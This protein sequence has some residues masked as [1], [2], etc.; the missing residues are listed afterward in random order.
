MRKGA[1]AEDVSISILE[2]LGYSI[3]ERRKAIMVGG[4]KVAEVDLIAKDPEG[5]ILTVEVKSGKASVT[6][7]RQVFSNSKLLNAKP[8]LV[9]KGFSDSSA[10]SLASELGVHYLLLPEYYLFTFEDFKEVAREIVY[11]VLNLY[12]SLDI[13]SITEEWEKIVEAIAGSNNFSEAAAKLR[14]SEED[15][16]KTVSNMG[17]FKPSGQTFSHLRLQALFVKS[18]LNEKRQLEN[19]EQRIEVLDEKINRLMGYRN[20]S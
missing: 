12:L 1:S 3:L 5:N 11:E 15:L 18:K 14:I 13:D 19:I 4:V 2:N 17:F 16:G 8:L 10:L 20:R 7:V 9:C 6:D